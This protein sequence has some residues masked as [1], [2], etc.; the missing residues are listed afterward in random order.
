MS[1][2]LLPIYC[3]IHSQVT[4][5]CNQLPHMLYFS[6]SA[7]GTILVVRIAP[8]RSPRDKWQSATAIIPVQVWRLCRRRVWHQQWPCLHSLEIQWWGNAQQMDGTWNISMDLWL[9]SLNN[10]TTHSFQI[11]PEVRGCYNYI[12][13]IMLID[14]LATASP[15]LVENYDIN[16]LVQDCGITTANALEISQS[17]IQPSISLLLI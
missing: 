4:S 15:K 1:Y 12:V 6:L 14:D 13:N 9:I 16:G 11:H 3:L 7:D 5:V 10:E 8:E 17:Y 2:L